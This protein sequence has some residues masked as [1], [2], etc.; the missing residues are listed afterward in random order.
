[1]YIYTSKLQFWLIFKGTYCLN[2]RV[3]GQCRWA[4]MKLFQKSIQLYTQLVI[5]LGY[6]QNFLIGFWFVARDLL[7]RVRMK[8]VFFV[9]WLCWLNYRKAV[10]IFWSVWNW[11]VE[12]FGDLTN[13]VYRV[14]PVT[15]C[16]ISSR[17]KCGRCCGGL[18]IL[19]L[20]SFC[21][22]AR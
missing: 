16:W 8:C 6:L 9:Q 7:F 5:N 2:Q 21:S 11:R 4:L 14:L 20:V 13:R 10:D 18:Y 19:W 22:S 15:K 17:S 12:S 1:M 3:Q